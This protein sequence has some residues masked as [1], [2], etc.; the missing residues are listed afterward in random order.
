MGQVAVIAKMTA[1]E[2]RRDELVKVLQ[3]LVDATESEPG[4]LFYAMNTSGTSPEDVWFY[5]VYRDNDALGAHGGSETMKKA[6]GALAD[7][8]A[9]RPELHLL[10]LVSGKNLPA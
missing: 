8:L 6:G 1:K 2:G 10:E 9:G 3:E 4:T 7:L 5:E